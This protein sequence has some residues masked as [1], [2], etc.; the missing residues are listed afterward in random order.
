MEFASS[1]IGVKE[2]GQSV[3]FIQEKILQ[4]KVIVIWHSVT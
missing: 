2:I 1:F 3:L 4:R